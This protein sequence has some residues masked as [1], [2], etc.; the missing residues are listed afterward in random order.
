MADSELARD[1]AHLIHSLHNR[2]AQEQAH[3]WIKGRGAILYDQ[4]GREFLD[5]LAGLW[6]VVVGHGRTELAEAAHRQMSEL[7]YA[8]AYAGSTSRPAIALAE[9]LAAICYPGIQRF[10][11]TSG[12]AESNESA[13]KT[14]RF[15]WKVR[16]RP[17]K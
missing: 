12:G 11:F 1:G 6:N 14:A 8:T 15:Y 10:F 16:G 17:E 3:V 9:R 4:S 2:A 7:A 13:F 5:A